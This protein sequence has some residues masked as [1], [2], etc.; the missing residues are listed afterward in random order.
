MISEK[1]PWADRG[2]AV[3]ICSSNSF[4]AT[5]GALRRRIKIRRQLQL[6]AS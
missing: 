6:E 1:Y 2:P 4:G 5:P 3:K